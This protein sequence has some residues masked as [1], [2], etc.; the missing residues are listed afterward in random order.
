MAK[1]PVVAA[2]FFNL[3][4]KAFI[5][6]L[7][8]YD[9]EHKDLEGGVLGL[10]KAYYGCVE[11]Q[12]CGTLHCH[13]LI[14]LEGG[15]NP[16]ENGAAVYDALC[17]SDETEEAKNGEVRSY[18]FAIPYLMYLFIFS[19]QNFELTEC[20]ECTGDSVE[21]IVVV[22]RLEPTYEVCN[23]SLSTQVSLRWF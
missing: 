13:M 12:G 21:D 23:S 8:G 2:Q 7:L 17:V 11:A 10:V 1:N 3:H 14:W 4:I 19:T 18:D 15:L 16:N 5:S 9:P 6:A 22:A 20:V